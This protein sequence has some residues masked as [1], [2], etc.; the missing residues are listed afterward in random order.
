MPTQA[1]NGKR[2]FNQYYA[3]CHNTSDSA[4][5]KSGPM[6]KHYYRHQPPPGDSIVRRTIQQGKGR[7]PAL[8][9]LDSSQVNDLIAY[10][11]TL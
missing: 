11:K 3:A 2:T 8:S 6:L 7:M 4:T 1:I 10:L 9:T 5:T